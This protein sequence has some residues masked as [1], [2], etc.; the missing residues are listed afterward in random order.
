MRLLPEL[1]RSGEIWASTVVGPVWVAEMR[2]RRTECVP[3][4]SSR[5]DCSSPRLVPLTVVPSRAYPDPCPPPNRPE[6][7]TCTRYGQPGSVIVIVPTVK[8]V[9]L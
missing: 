9:E 7:S 4:M 5:V 8:N 2:D 1:M 3:A 6:A